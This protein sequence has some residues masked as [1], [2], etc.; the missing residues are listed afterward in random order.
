[1][2]C[3][4]VCMLYTKTFTDKKIHSLHYQVKRKFVKTNPG[5]FF[6]EQECE[7]FSRHRK[8]TIFFRWLVNSIEHYFAAKKIIGSRSSFSIQH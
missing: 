1:M 5:F 6:Q 8:L 3:K 7:I 4:I 2:G